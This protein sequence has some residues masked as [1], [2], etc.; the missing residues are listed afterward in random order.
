MPSQTFH[1]LPEAKKERILT[2]ALN[3]FSV[4]PLKEARVSAIIA[5]A[6]IS[7]GAFYKYFE[8]LEDLY[9]YFYDYAKVDAHQ[10]IFDV[11]QENNGD[12]FL[13]LKDYFRQILTCYSREIYA[14]YYRMMLLHE[15][16]FQKTPKVEEIEANS[17]LEIQ[18]RFFQLIDTKQL[19]LENG[20]EYQEFIVFLTTIMHDLIKDHLMEQQP[21]AKTTAQFEQRM[22][23]LAYG[24]RTVV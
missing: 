8:N 21:I 3:E 20:R 1:N 16:D 4:H 23:W 12:L 13:A 10:L 2:A 11:L 18:K 9:I 17:S 19:K 14:D 15:S 24:I 6:E 5:E 22:H 7:R